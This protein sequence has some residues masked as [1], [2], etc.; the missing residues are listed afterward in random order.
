MLTVLCTIALGTRE[1]SS[2]APRV[3]GL[4]VLVP[5]RIT[6]ETAMAPGR[7]RRETELLN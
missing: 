5:L 6:V 2:R 1:E 4:E 3:T 7:P